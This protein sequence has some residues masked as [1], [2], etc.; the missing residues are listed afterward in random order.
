ME[1]NEVIAELREGRKILRQIAPNASERLFVLLKLVEEKAIQVQAKVSTM[2][3]ETR[4]RLYQ[5][6]RSQISIYAGKRDGGLATLQDLY[7]KL[8]TGET[9]TCECCGCK[10]NGKGRHLAECQI[11]KDYFEFFTD[12]SSHA[13]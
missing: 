3:T 11:V 9:I 4:E 2:A 5:Q 10:I 8:E 13:G 7:N 12:E 1:L 6:L